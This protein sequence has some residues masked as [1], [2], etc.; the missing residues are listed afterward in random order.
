MNFF[1]FGQI[2]PNTFLDFLLLGYGV[3]WLLVFGYVMSLYFQQRN[4]QRDIDLLKQL[5]REE[6]GADD[7]TG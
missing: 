7:G 2:D 4:I 1:I 5:L 6:D 3:M